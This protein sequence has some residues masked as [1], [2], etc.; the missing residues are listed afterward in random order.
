MQQLDDLKEKTKDKMIAILFWAVW[1]PECEDIRMLF[2]DLCIDHNHIKFAWVSPYY[3]YKRYS[4][5]LFTLYSA[6][7]DFNF[8]S[9]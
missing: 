8:F 9:L 6:A 1:Y 7:H 5:S 4:F 3:S 2:E